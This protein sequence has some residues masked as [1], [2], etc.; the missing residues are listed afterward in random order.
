[1]MSLD[2]LNS[3]NKV[4]TLLS[5]QLA[6]IVNN[7]DPLLTTPLSIESQEAFHSAMR[8]AYC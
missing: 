1:M 3:I 4:S 5:F 6:I 8:G 7:S 2:S